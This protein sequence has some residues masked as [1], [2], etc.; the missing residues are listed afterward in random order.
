MRA[1]WLDYLRIV[2]AAAVWLF[3]LKWF[4]YGYLG[5]PIFFAI[6]GFVIAHSAQERD[7]Y[8]FAT[9]RLAR[10]W[11]AF[12]LCMTVTIATSGEAPDLLRLAANITMAPRAFGQQPFDAVYWSLMFEMLFYG[13]V[14]ALLIGRNFTR[15]LHWFCWAWL[16]ACALNLAY[17]LPAKVILSLDWAAY[18]CV[19]CAVWL[20]QQRV[21]GAMTLWLAS[22]VVATIAAAMQTR[23][24]PVIAG[25]IVGGFAL[26]LPWL[27]A[28]RPSTTVG[29]TL[30]AMSYP[31]YLL[32][33]EFGD[34]VQTE[35]G[36]AAS[37]AIVLLTS[38]AVTRIEPYGSAAIKRAAAAL[39][40]SPQPV[41]RG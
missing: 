20:M 24:D 4:D 40:G 15:R 31:L 5:V 41:R 3:H 13:Y 1:G 22:S 12:L 6:S 32:H 14:G 10:L 18:F 37:V 27:A 8:S 19:G 38:W 36:L 21:R 34:A 9:A 11:P 28:N 7:R 39:R 17:P 33:H 26:A 16:A 29:L 25:A 23:F 30:G 35:W 2:A